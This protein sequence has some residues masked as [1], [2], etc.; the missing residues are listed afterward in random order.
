ME[1]KNYVALYFEYD[2]KSGKILFKERFVGEDQTERQKQWNTRFAG[3]EAGYIADNGYR[4]VRLPNGRFLYAH[5]MAFL[6]EIGEIPEVVDHINLKKL[7][8]RFSNLRAATQGENTRNVKRRKNNKAKLK[9][10]SWSKSNNAWRMDIQH[11][12]KKYFSYHETKEKAYEEYC[13]MSEK[14]H[15]EFGNVK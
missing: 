13:S 12:G 15:G 7:D 5:Q 3:K 6:L 14:L 4:R 11:E 2:V 8:N 10:V 1:L 9:G